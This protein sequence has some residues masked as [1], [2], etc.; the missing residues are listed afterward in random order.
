MERVVVAELRT[1]NAI[2]STLASSSQLVINGHPG[3]GRG[4]LRFY[5][6]AAMGRCPH[7]GNYFLGCAIAL[8][9]AKPDIRQLLNEAIQRRSDHHVS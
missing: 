8:E 4:P 2:E 1:H 7:S 3:G 9:A 6:N 5:F